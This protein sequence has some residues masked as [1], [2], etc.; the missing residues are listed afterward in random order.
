MGKF[1]QNKTSCSSHSQGDVDIVFIENYYDP[2]P[3]DT[4]YE[5]TLIFLVRC[6]GELKI[7][8]DH[9]LC[10]IFDLDSRHDLLMG[11]RFELEKLNFVNSTFPEGEYLPMLVCTKSL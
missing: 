9:H 8:T 2:D 3:K 4:S 6:G 11:I 7:H 5:A 1:K 10:G